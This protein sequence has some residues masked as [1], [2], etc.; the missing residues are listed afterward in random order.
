MK[1]ERPE[2]GMSY[3]REQ[4]I[5]TFNCFWEQEV[6]PINKM[7]E[8]GVEVFTKD[9]CFYPT[10]QWTKN[11]H[12]DAS[13]KA[14]LIKIEPIKQETCADICRDL[15]DPAWDSSSLNSLQDRAK[16]AL[17]REGK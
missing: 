15:L 11:E 7:L 1:I 12:I 16:A 2:F 6:E 14:I 9:D 4:M 13:H 17:E 5:E 8:A 3:T 10:A